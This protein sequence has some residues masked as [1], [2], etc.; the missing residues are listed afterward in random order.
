MNADNFGP[1]R[2]VNILFSTTL[3]AWIT[4]RF[5]LGLEKH[6][7]ILSKNGYEDFVSR[8][9]LRMNVGRSQL[10][11]RLTAFSIYQSWRGWISLLAKKPNWLRVAG[12]RNYS[13]VLSSTRFVSGRGPGPVVF[14]RYFGPA[15]AQRSIGCDF[16]AGKC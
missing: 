1:K 7:E 3:F 15:V 2:K 6:V 14:R 11:Q 16:F 4:V 9:L 13:S 12:K 10:Y 8:R 5:F